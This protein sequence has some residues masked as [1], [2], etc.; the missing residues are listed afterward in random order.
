MLA[1][2]INVKIIPL[3]IIFPMIAGIRN[4]EGILKFCLWGLVGTIPFIIAWIGAGPAFISNIFGYGSSLQ[5]WGFQLLLAKMDPLIQFETTFVIY[6]TL[7]KLLIIVSVLMLSYYGYKRHMGPAKLPACAYILFL[8]FS[9][10]FGVQYMV[11]LTPVLLAVNL[12]WG[13]LYATI[14]GIFI[15]SIYY[16]YLIFIY[17]LQPNSYIYAF[18]FQTYHNGYMP[19]VSTILG[20]LTWSLLVILLWALL[21]RKSNRNAG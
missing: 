13:F 1:A 11:Y 14:S 16:H 6:Y 12:R 2:A 9:P 17:P 15:G 10:G 8:I 18:P 3:L 4:W 7:G 20:V 5:P 21:F 19:A